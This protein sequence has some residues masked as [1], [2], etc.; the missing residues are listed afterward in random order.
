MLKFEG[1]AL[2]HR[3]FRLFLA[4]HFLWTLATQIQ[5]VAVSWQIYN[6]THSPLA[7]GY[8][9]LSQFIPMAIFTLPAGHAADRIDRRLIMIAGFCVEVITAAIFL[10]LAITHA[11]F[12][13]PFFGVLALF[14]VARSFVGPAAQSFVPNLVPE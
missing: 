6:V 1:S 14:G 2:A 3:D 8:V 11:H 5:S 13:W 12:V 7:L 9:G 10:A 4:I